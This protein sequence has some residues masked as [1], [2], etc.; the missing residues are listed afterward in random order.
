MKVIKIF[1]KGKLWE[2]FLEEKT[3]CGRNRNPMGIRIHFGSNPVK[4]EPC[5]EGILCG[6]IPVQEESGV[7]GITAGGIPFRD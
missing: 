6:R 5:V 1:L 2:K 4:E 7:G 3:S